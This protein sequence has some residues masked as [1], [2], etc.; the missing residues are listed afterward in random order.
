MIEMIKEVGIFIVI[1]QA[2][3]YLVPGENYEKYVKVIV[4]IIM[5]AKMVQPVL[6]LFSEDAVSDSLD[7][8]LEQSDTIFEIPEEIEELALEDKETVILEEIETEMEQ[9]LKEN[10]IEGYRAKELMISR[11]PTGEAAKIIITVS[12]EEGGE[13]AEIKIEKVV[14]GEER[15]ENTD[16]PEKEEEALKE[17]YGQILGIAPQ[18][19]EIN[20][21]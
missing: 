8:F 12:K 16:I 9:R 13:N 7:A 3:L 2:V 19:I 17:Y 18:Q 11:E 14:I 4:G 1:A 15:K 6:T 5:I 20:M 21:N 10:P